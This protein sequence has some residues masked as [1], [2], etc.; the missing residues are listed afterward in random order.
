MIGG[1][2]TQNVG[3]TNS[4][5][6]FSWIISSTLKYVWNVPK[7]CL[8]H[9]GDGQEVLEFQ[10][11]SPTVWGC[12]LRIS[13]APQKKN[14]GYDLFLV[15][16]SWEEKFPHNIG[17][18]I[19]HIFRTSHKWKPWTSCHLSHCEDSS[20]CS[21]LYLIHHPSPIGILEITLLLNTW[22]HDIK[23]CTYTV[24]R[25]TS[26]ASANFFFFGSFFVSFTSASWSDPLEA[27]R[28]LKINSA[29]LWN[30]ELIHTC[31]HGR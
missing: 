15:G 18:G 5:Q 22:N 7:I 12:F 6:F 3:C 17:F 29:L 1:V 9:I 30:P 4:T 31:G 26:N 14:Y 27:I 24:C 23:P 25:K 13:K 19:G 11:N 21:I 10:L 16:G 2:S 20:T 28:P 8:E